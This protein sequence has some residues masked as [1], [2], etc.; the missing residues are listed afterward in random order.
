MRSR[1]PYDC[2]PPKASPCG[3]A[4]FV[5]ARLPI[6]N[7]NHPEPAQ[8]TCFGTPCLC[9]TPLAVLCT[10]PFSQLHYSPSTPP[11]SCTTTINF[12]LCD[13]PPAAPVHGMVLKGIGV[14]CTGF[15][16]K[17]CGQWSPPTELV[18]TGAL[19]GQNEGKQGRTAQG[20]GG[21]G[22]TGGPWV[23]ITNN[24]SW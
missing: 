4:G 10:S 18:H 5:M 11:L 14:R 1:R 15:S 9:T 24:A 21:R 23:A 12:T 2:V 20:G 3:R 22:E 13:I 19:N 8:G 7:A 16:L 6:A 17:C